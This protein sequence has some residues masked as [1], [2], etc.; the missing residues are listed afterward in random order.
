MRERFDPSWAPDAASNSALPG[1][2]AFRSSRADAYDVDHAA[3]IA[4]FEH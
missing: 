4:A 2:P 3:I 1:A